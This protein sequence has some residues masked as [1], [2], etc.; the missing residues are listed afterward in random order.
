MAKN[1]KGKMPDAEK[2]KDK[3]KTNSIQYFSTEQAVQTMLQAGMQKQIL[4]NNIEP[5]EYIN[6]EDIDAESIYGNNYRQSTFDI[7]DA[8]RNAQEKISNDIKNSRKKQ[9]PPNSGD[10]SQ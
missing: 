7:L 6:R 8:G 5:A 1:I 4:A 3:S 2:F 9:R 10:N